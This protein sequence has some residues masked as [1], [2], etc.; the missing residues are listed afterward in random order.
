MRPSSGTPMLLLTGDRCRGR[1][2]IRVSGREVFLT[3][4]LF[5]VL[6]DLVH[7][8]LTTSQGYSPI[9][10]ALGD[11]ERARLLVHRLRRA[12]DSAAGT[13]EGRRL[14]ERGIGTEYRLASTPEGIAVDEDFFDLPQGTA[15]QEVLALLRSLPDC[16]EGRTFRHEGACQPPRLDATDFNGTASPQPYRRQPS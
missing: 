10:S 12:I 2:G 1:I 16:R 6:L 15:P 13:G 7:A 5:S 14:I 3:L 11:P 8:R 9:P 4:G